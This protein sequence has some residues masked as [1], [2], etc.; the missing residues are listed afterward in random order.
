MYTFYKLFGSNVVM[1]RQHVE[2]CAMKEVTLFSYDAKSKDNA[3]QLMQI[4]RFPFPC[5]KSFCGN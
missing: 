2:M 5:L 4:N 3:K 1:C